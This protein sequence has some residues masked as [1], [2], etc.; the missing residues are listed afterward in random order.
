LGSRWRFVDDS[1]RRPNPA[2]SRNPKRI[3]LQRTRR[4]SRGRF[5]GCGPD[6]W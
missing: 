5:G 6:G 3:S 4:S 2:T 1:Q